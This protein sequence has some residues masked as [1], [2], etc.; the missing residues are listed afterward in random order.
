MAS[1]EALSQRKVF[2]GALDN[3]QK[4]VLLRTLLLGAEHDQPFVIA[5]S[6][7]SPEVLDTVERT[8][9]DRQRLEL[10]VHGKGSGVEV[11]RL[12][13]PKNKKWRLE[14]SLCCKLMKR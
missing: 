8:G 9:S 12:V 7:S 3:C 5:P 11:V 14:E 2:H 4:Y 13:R 1:V 6:E 10:E